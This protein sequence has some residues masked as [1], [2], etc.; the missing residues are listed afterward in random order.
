MISSIVTE[1]GIKIALT[2]DTYL[3]DTGEIVGSDDP[4]RRTLIGRAGMTV[5]VRPDLAPGV[6]VFQDQPEGEKK[7]KAERGPKGKKAAKP[8]EDKAVKPDEDKGQPEGEKEP[9]N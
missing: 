8:T 2:R 4:A 1:D 3:T 7:P 6:E 9:E 5:Q